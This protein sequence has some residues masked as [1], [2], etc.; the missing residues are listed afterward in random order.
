MYTKTFRYSQRVGGGRDGSN[1]DRRETTI[2]GSLTKYAFDST[3]Q[4]TYRLDLQP[5]GNAG[6]GGERAK[7]VQS[8]FQNHQ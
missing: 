1:D 4:G 7:E 8:L 6:R 5:E 3:P 2:N